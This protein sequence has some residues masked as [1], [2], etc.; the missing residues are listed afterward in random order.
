MFQLAQVLGLS[1]DMVY[2]L[3]KDEWAS[4]LREV[5]SFTAIERR[6]VFHLAYER[7]FCTQTLDA[8][9]LH[10]R[11]PTSQAPWWAAIPLLAAIL[12]RC[13]TVPAHWWVTDWFEHASLGI[14]LLF[15]VPLGGVYA[16][17]RLVL[18]IGQGWVLQSIGLF[19]LF[20]SLYAAGMA[21]IH[22]TPGGSSRTCFSATRRSCWWGWSCIPS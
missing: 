2:R 1:P 11:R 8:I 13:G 16:A 15:A 4:C 19:S 18:P 9:A 3:S 14:A 20:T 6:R 21:T 5:K 22:A 12:F 7:R 17:V 10:V